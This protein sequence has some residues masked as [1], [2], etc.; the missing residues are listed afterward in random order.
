MKKLSC[1]PFFFFSLKYAWI[2]F[3]KG[4]NSCMKKILL[5]YLSLTLFLSSCVI[6]NAVV[7]PDYDFSKVKRIRVNQFSSAKRYKGISDTVQNA[8]IQDLLAKGYDI[9]SDINVK[10]DCVIDGSVTS[11]YRIRE[12]WIYSGFYYGYPGRYSRRY[13]WTGMPIYDGVICD[14]TVNIGISTRMTDVE[15]GQVVWLDSFN[16]ESW[17][18][19]SAINRAVKAVLKSLPKEKVASKK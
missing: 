11:F 10:V 19:D 4:I 2:V 18:E 15:T 13:W 14:N 12:E 5:M 17:D 9:V 6:N 3:L 8:F 16:N 7:K 1:F